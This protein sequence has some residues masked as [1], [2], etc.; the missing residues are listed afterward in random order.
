MIKAMM[1]K[2]KSRLT[3]YKTLEN[4]PG[5]AHF[6]N[7]TIWEKRFINYLQSVSSHRLPIYEDFSAPLRYGRVEFGFERQRPSKLNL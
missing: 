6:L 5:T 1:K 3:C 7:F 2:G 4:P